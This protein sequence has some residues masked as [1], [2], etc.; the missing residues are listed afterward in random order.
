MWVY[1]G[2][3][4]ASPVRTAYIMFT[5]MKFKSLPSSF[6]CEKF[7]LKSKTFQIKLV[8]KLIENLCPKSSTRSKADRPPLNFSQPKHFIVII[9]THFFQ[10]RKKLISEN[11]WII[12][13]YGADQ[14]WH[15]TETIIAATITTKKKTSHLK[16]YKHEPIFF[17]FLF[18]LNTDF[19]SILHTEQKSGSDY[20]LI[21]FEQSTNRTWTIIFIV[22]SCSPAEQ[23]R[24]Y[25]CTHADPFRYQIKRRRWFGYILFFLYLAGVP[26][27]SASR[28]WYWINKF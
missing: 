9:K 26:T 12:S 18:S 23:W 8:L 20:D 2:A 17:L 3:D 11:H 22:I 14:Q 15:I 16:T 19:S 13:V 21:I 6:K 5:I 10:Y 24:A 1:F 28:R 25:K 27:S 4:C 7:S